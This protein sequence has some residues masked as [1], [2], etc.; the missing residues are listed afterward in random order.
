MPR[1]RRGRSRRSTQVPRDF[2]EGAYLAIGAVAGELDAPY[3]YQP[4]AR[5]SASPPQAA[6]RAEGGDRL[7]DARGSVAAVEV[8][9]QFVAALCGPALARLERLDQVLRRAKQ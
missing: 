6:S 5:L 1:P 9:A 7:A 3:G 4:R 8:F 2:S